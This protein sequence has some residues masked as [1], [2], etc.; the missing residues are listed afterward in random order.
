VLNQERPPPL[1]GIRVLDLT[2]VWAGP[3]AT[4]SL[5]F[6]GADVIRIEAPGRLDPWRGGISGGNRDAYPDRVYGE[7]PYNRFVGFNTQNHD[8][9]SISLDLKKASGRELVLD[10]A[11]KSDVV[12]ANYTPGVLE[13]LGLGYA[14]LRARRPDIIVVEMP[15][16]GLSGPDAH[17][18]GM[19][20]TMEAASGMA[21]M[22]GYG[23]GAPR[24]SGPAYLDPIGGLHG[25]AAV[26]TALANRARTGEGQHIEVAQ[27]EAALHWVG[28]LVLEYLENGTMPP[29]HGNRLSWAAPHGAF[30]CA[31]DD[32]WIAIAV[33]TDDQWQALRASFGNPA[34]LG[35]SRFATIPARLS[36]VD[37]LEARLGALTHAR[38]RHELARLLQEHGVPAAPVQ[39]GVDIAADP[40]LR[41]R[42]FLR[43]LSHPEAGEHDYPGLAFRLSRSPGAM[44]R[45]APCFGE[46]NRE[47]LTEVLALSDEQ[48][49]ELFADGVVHDRPLAGY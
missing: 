1:A 21:T 6:L 19:G 30:R 4:R 23:D 5:A 35:D 40:H 9:R 46:H 12:I 28:E 2:A 49:D 18:S 48:V 29:P 36:N 10:L 34:E 24:L 39:L 47:V 42:G 17:H 38:D 26:L 13:R 3:M 16:F 32:E 31:G 33:F 22:M 8:K 7:R 25:A 27:M 11:S 14:D 20:M 41:A 43:R 44:R 45:A 15:A 37:D